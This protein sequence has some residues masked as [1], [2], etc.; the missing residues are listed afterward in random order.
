[1]LLLW[2]PSLSTTATCRKVDESFVLTESSSTAS[3]NTIQVFIDIGDALGSKETDVRLRL[4]WNREVCSSKINSVVDEAW[5]H[6]YEAPF[7]DK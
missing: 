6:I 7:V 2:Y 3:Q 1:M 5:A 4:W